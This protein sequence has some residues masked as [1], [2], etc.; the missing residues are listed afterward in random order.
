[1]PA[2]KSDG[3]RL[4]ELLCSQTGLP[5]GTDENV[6]LGA[7]LSAWRARA[8]TAGLP[9]TAT[10]AETFAAEQKAKDASRLSAA[11]HAAGG[12]GNNHSTSGVK[13][14]TAE[15][16]QDVV[17]FGIHD[18]LTRRRAEQT[19]EALGKSLRDALQDGDL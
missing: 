1:M 9:A 10:V 3:E 19:E 5:A 15:E 7:Y 2:K 16:A 8:V 14:L 6:I 4:Y 11:L 18:R 17:A 12:A 13:M